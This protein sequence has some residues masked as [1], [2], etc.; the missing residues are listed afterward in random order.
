MASASLTD[1][2]NKEPCVDAVTDEHGPKPPPPSVGSH[3]KNSTDS[4]PSMNPTTEDLGSYNTQT[5]DHTHMQESYALDS[6]SSLKRENEELKDEIDKLKSKVERLNQ[7][8]S[9]LQQRL[10]KSGIQVS[11]QDS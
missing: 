10:K 2:V 4:L 7:D 9:I 11:E 1:T 6:D 3:T 5:V 8:N